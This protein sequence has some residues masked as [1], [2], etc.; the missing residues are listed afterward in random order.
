MVNIWGHVGTVSFLTTLFLGK[1]DPRAVYQYLVPILLPETD[2]LPIFQER[3]C[4]MWGLIL[5]PLSY[6][7]DMRN[8]PS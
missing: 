5:G 1:P 4:W 7:G 3:M 6:E 2:N 8:Q